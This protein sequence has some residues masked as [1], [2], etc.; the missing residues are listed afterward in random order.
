MLEQG[1]DEAYLPG[2]Q[3]IINGKKKALGDASWVR[4]RRC[5][6]PL[7]TSTLVHGFSFLALYI[8][9]TN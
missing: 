3:V 6:P 4:K 8:V 7:R 5:L 9:Y 2:P 1:S